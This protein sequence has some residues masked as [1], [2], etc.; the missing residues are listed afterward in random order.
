[1]N[2][3]AFGV[4]KA[5]LIK[6]PATANLM[7]DSFDRPLVQDASGIEISSPWN[8]QIYRPQSLIQGY[9]TRIGTT[10]VVLEWCFPNVSAS[11]GNNKLNFID[12]SGV[13]RQVV[14][15]DGNYTVEQALNGVV[16][17]MNVFALPGY[18]FA[19]DVDVAGRVA[20]ANTAVGGRTFSVV[21]NQ[22]S[23]QL[24]ICLEGNDP[25]IP[26]NTPQLV[27]HLIDCPDLRP[28]RFIDFT[29]AQLTA[30]Q[31]VKDA[32]TDPD[33]RDVLCRW[34]FAYDEQ[35]LLD[36]YGFPILM[37][38]TKFCTRRIFNPPKQIK[39][40]QN[41]PVGSLI[42]QVYG[43]DN[44]IIQYEAPSNGLPFNPDESNW[45]MTLQLS[46]G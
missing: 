11:K 33:G 2:T 40:E 15:T 38:Y 17:L 8:F 46:E 27:E 30:V 3:S 4:E 19:V 22:L 44:Q 1:M 41:Y 25:N 9:F 42:F 12:S 36:A 28:F 18:T 35:N 45:L 5:V 34:Y 29:C 6:V 23:I 37:G 31:D 13:Q 43:D 14:L 39:W 20:L 26:L 32:S 24:G 21:E 10:E 7:I 16:E